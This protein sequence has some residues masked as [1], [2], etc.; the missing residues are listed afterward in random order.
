MDTGRYCTWSVC[1]CQT[2]G[3]NIPV[4]VHQ[5]KLTWS[6]G[7]RGNWV[8]VKSAG[9]LRP[10]GPLLSAG[11]LDFTGWN[12]VKSNGALVLERMLWRKSAQMVTGGKAGA[13]GAVI[14]NFA[15]RLTF[16]GMAFSHAARAAVFASGWSWK[17]YSS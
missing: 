14:S 3:N 7:R 1:L 8:P 12:C 6:L 13:A 4:S 11:W 2:L 15:R 9:M 17:A 16:L 10:S 5:F